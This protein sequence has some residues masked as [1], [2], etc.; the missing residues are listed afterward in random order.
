MTSSLCPISSNVGEE[1]VLCSVA[2][3]A[4]YSPGE[5][6]IPRSNFDKLYQCRITDPQLSVMVSVEVPTLAALV[7]PSLIS[8]ES[9]FF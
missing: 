1:S 4:S 8:L 7:K 9:I 5:S 2:L 6:A 3:L